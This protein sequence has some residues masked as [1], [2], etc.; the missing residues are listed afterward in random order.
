MEFPIS[1]SIIQ[2]NR[3]YEG[4]SQSST[5]TRGAWADKFGYS[6]GR[7]LR[8]FFWYEALTHTLHWGTKTRD[9][10]SLRVCLDD[11][12]GVLFGPMTTSFRRASLDGM[13]YL[14]WRCVSLMFVGRTLDLCFEE[15][16]AISWFLEL[17]YL[18]DNGGGI[19]RIDLVRQQVRLKV[20]YRASS[21][22]RSLVYHFKR[23]VIESFQELYP[24]DRRDPSKVSTSPE[25]HIAR[26]RSEL[27]SL[28]SLVPRIYDI[29]RF[30]SDT[31]RKLEAFV[32]TRS[33]EPSGYQ[34]ELSRLALENRAMRDE[35][36]SLK[37]R[38]RVIGR[39]RPLLKHEISCTVCPLDDMPYIVPYSDRV[40]LFSAREVRRKTFVFDRVLTTSQTELF[41]EIRPV[42]DCAVDGYN[43]CVFAY[44]PTNSG[45]S[46][47][48]QGTVDDPGMTL[49]AIERI[50]RQ[51]EFTRKSF[52]I[53]ISCHQIYNETVMDL[54]NGMQALQFKTSPKDDGFCVVDGTSVIVDSEQHALAVVN[55]ASRMRTTKST[56]LNDYSSRSHFIVTVYIENL[57]ANTKGKLHLI[58]LAGSENVNKSGASGQTLRETQSINKSLSALGDVIQALL[59]K[60]K[61]SKPHI[62]FRNSKLTMLLKDSLLGNSKTLMIVQLSPSDTDIGETHNSLAFAQR[63]RNVEVGRPYRNQ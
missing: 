3:V 12:V 21:L 26:L 51:I 13:N 28:R 47:T 14:P 27:N 31:I 11:V 33:S 59:V 18:T 38:I 25:S 6:D 2:R 37:G 1:S 42:V 24:A 10:L 17:Q 62:P 29:G 45:K 60:P 30:K 4:Q 15:D 58:D 50:F 40:S 7:V 34:A 23:T 20:E 57:L 32:L 35:L 9:Q 16:V 43:V 46:Y 56:N 44:G 54:L 55:D 41:D 49:L 22:G 53:S 52:R 36:I 8:R 61:E 19:A 5:L 48:M 39:V 63:V